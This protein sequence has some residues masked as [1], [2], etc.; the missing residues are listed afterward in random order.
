LR[1]LRAPVKYGDLDAVLRA[2]NPGGILVIDDL[3]AGDTTTDEQ[4]AEKDALRRALLNDPD[5]HA[6]ELDASSGLLVASKRRAADG[7]G[8]AAT[9]SAEVVSG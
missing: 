3:A 4:Q 8:R 5:L 6:V 2:L 7:S 9:R 1:T